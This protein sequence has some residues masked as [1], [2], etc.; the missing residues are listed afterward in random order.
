MKKKLPLW[1]FCG[2]ALSMPLHLSA[3]GVKTVKRGTSIELNAPDGYASYQWQVS[4]NGGSSYCDL[5]EGDRQNTTAKV[6]IPSIYRVKATN[7]E[8]TTEYP[9]NDTINTEEVTFTP[10]V[11]KA[12]AA[13]GYVEKLDGTIG[14]G[15]GIPGADRENG[16]PTFSKKLTNWNSLDCMAVYY[17]HHPKAIVDT[18]MVITMKILQTAT[19][20]LSV[21]D[22]LSPDE[23]MAQT[24]ISVRGKGR[25]DTLNIMGLDIPKKGYYRYQLE[26]LSGNNNIQ[27]IDRFLFSATTTAKSYVANYISSPS[28]HLSSWRSTKPGAPTGAAYDWCYQ[29]VMMPK[30]SD[31]IGTYVMSLGVLSGYMGI[32]MNGYKDGQPKHDVIFSIWDKG[33]TDVDPDLPEHLRAGAVDWSDITEISRF[34]NEGTGSKS[35][36][37]GNHWNSGTFVQFITNSRKEEAEYT[38]IVDG[39]EQIKKQTNMLV[40][41]WFNAQDGKGWQYISTTRL[42]GGNHNFDSWYSFLENYNYTSGQY[43]RTGYYRNGYGRAV[44]T[45]KWFHFNRV[46]FGNTDGGS[47]EGAR[48]DFEQGVTDDFPGTFYMRTGGY[49][50]TKKTANMV[51]LNTDDTPVD[52]INLEALTQRVDLAV[53]NEIDRIE[54]KESFEKNQLDKSKWK[55]IYYSSQE[56]SGEGS[57]GRAQQTIDGNDDTYWHSQWTGGRAQYPHTIVVDTQEEI[58]AL[59]FQILMS[60]GTNRYIKAFDLYASDDNEEWTLI[61]TTEDAPQEEEF[62]FILPKAVKMRYFKLVIR[63]GRAND[64]PFVRI[65]EIKVAGNVVTGIGNANADL[66]AG[67]HLEVAATGKAGEFTVT[68]PA[69]TPSIDVSLYDVA[70]KLMT[71]KKYAYRIRG[72]KIKIAHPGCPAGPYIVKA[73]TNGRKY[74]GNIMLK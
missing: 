7:S 26:C 27:N 29:E 37:S 52:T 35:F 43:H 2:I 54:E 69:T 23:P 10:I 61:H 15:I 68:V 58:E 49:T 22:P 45:G 64:G 36:C 13:Q 5:P 59:G 50:G 40:S 53:Q 17:F 57:N 16:L 39:K 66:P 67:N 38:I 60:G 70:G 21:F 9:V 48:D 62:R 14:Y 3:D 41:A 34:G 30:E 18:R 32:Q 73:T 25:A 12:T 19:F 20:R 55:V 47:N 44:D 4:T 1:L 65:N 42:P 56:E 31:I 63:D 71:S 24:Y 72:E 74:S 51:P 33:D 46:N 6:F 28:V 11:S 8:N